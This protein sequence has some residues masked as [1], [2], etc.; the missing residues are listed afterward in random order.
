MAIKGMKG[1]FIIPAKSMA[2]AKIALTAFVTAASSLRLSR[3]W[4]RRWALVS[5]RSS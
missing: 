4:S 5:V 1:F 3:P 2:V